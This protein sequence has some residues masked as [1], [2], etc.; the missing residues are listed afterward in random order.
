MLEKDDGNQDAHV[1]LILRMI[2][3][4]EGR[5]SGVTTDP[6]QH[7]S[8]WNFG[9]E[10]DKATFHD[11]K[12]QD[13]EEMLYNMLMTRFSNVALI[14]G[15][16]PSAL[17]LDRPIL[18]LPPSYSSVSGPNE[19]Q[20]GSHGDVKVTKDEFWNNS[21]EQ[22][23][24]NRGNLS[25]SPLSN[26]L[27]LDKPL[28]PIVIID[29]LEQRPHHEY[30]AQ[31]EP[32]SIVNHSSNR[33]PFH[34]PIAK[35]SNVDIRNG[36]FSLVGKTP[37]GVASLPPGAMA[38]IITAVS[39]VPNSN[40]LHPP[41]YS[42]PFFRAKRFTPKPWRP[43]LSA[44][45][46]EDKATNPDGLPPDVGVPDEKGKEKDLIDG[47]RSVSSPSNMT[48][49]SPVSFSNP[50]GIGISR[51]FS[52]LP[53]GAMP[54][55]LSS[56][57]PPLAFIPATSGSL[58]DSV[59]SSPINPDKDLPPLIVQSNS[60]W[61]HH[62]GTTDAP[63]TVHK[64]ERVSTNFHLPPITTSSPLSL[65]PWLLVQCESPKAPLP[66]LPPP[67]GR[68]KHAG[69]GYEYLRKSSPHMQRFV[70]SLAER[71]WGG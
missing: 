4:E 40:E 62:D 30:T 52:A 11:D 42:A 54:P 34:H 60:N 53:P 31:R 45:D 55:Q 58:P 21:G 44:V 46:E 6:D 47:T 37:K 43:S 17:I 24:K 15:S 63:S 38:P 3:R 39:L 27:L 22:R 61:Y 13:A 2:E 14:T 59:P 35:I 69:P 41:Q 20:N 28:P 50:S 29:T 64:P 8:R 16:K 56:W 9:H 65:P 19:Y 51:G 66:P 7:S 68:P 49:C 33:K 67:K 57:P 48:L 12:Q 23:S 1:Q 26:Q 18:S 32:S 36:R 10:V 71:I 25:Q 5:D 70:E